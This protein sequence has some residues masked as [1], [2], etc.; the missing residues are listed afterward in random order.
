MQYKIHILKLYLIALSTSVSNLGTVPYLLIQ[1]SKATIERKGGE[2][3]WFHEW[4]IE[5]S[6]IHLTYLWPCKIH[7]SG[8]DFLTSLKINKQINKW[9]LG[10]SPQ[11]GLLQRSEK[12]QTGTACMHL[13]AMHLMQVKEYWQKRRQGIAVS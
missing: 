11:G 12:Q 6:R 4:E 5:S 1:Y 10:W 7:V 9:K 3:F 2:S 8:N 13:G